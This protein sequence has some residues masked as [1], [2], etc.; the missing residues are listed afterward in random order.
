MIKSI[1]W[2]AMV[3]ALVVAPV[4]GGAEQV[5]KGK[6]MSRTAPTSSGDDCETRIS[7]LESS[8][9]EGEERLAEKNQ[10]IDYCAG[11]HKRDKTID[12]LVKDCTRYEGQSIV[13]QQLVAECQLAAYSY[14]NAL[15]ALKAE[16]RR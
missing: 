4:P 1:L 13:R 3:L 7:K 2:C 15:S 8:Q 10:V 6:Q 11:Q 5:P 12:R 14:A 16:A 9:A